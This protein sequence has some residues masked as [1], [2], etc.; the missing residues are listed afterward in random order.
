MDFTIVPAV[1]I[2]LLALVGAV[3]VINKVPAAWQAVTYLA[4]AL[5]N[6]GYILEN[7]CP[8][9]RR[10]GYAPAVHRFDEGDGYVIELPTESWA[11]YA[12]AYSNI[13]Q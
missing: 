12:A 4:G 9:C 11:T 10:H 3:Q 1:A 2:L 13:G 5:V 6:V 7:Y 8:G